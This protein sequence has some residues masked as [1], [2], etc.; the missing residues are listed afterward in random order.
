ME[1][2]QSVF[3]IE[4]Q[5]DPDK[6][7]QQTVQLMID[8]EAWISIT[9][10]QHPIKGLEVDVKSANLS[11]EQLNQILQFAVSATSGPPTPQN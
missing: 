7:L 9:L 1:S 2:P 8:A 11:G 4:G 6:H 10:K 5:A 3:F